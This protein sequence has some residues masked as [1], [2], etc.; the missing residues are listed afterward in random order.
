MA[1]WPAPTRWGLCPEP[2]DT[3]ALARAVNAEPWEPLPGMVK[4][5]CSRGRYFFAV[6]AEAA[7]TT[8]ACPDCV[9]LGSR[10]PSDH[11]A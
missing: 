5:R 1:R 8:A 11:A 6:K 10:P 2:A 7:E 4:K 9:A 3:D